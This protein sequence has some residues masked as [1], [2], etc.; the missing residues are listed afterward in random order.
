MRAVAL[1]NVEVEGLG[2]LRESLERRG[3]SV[4]E[5]P[6]YK[7]EFPEVSDFDLLIVLGG[8]MGV[9][10][11]DKFPFLKREKELIRE[12]LSQG[13]KVLG[14]CLG[15]QL[16]AEV[17]GGKVYKGEWGKE[18]G[19]KLIYPQDHLEILYG[20]EITVFHWHGDTFEIPQGCVK[21]ASSQ[22]YKN[23][24]F[25]LGNQ[26]VGLQFH[27]EVTPEDVEGWISAYR[28]ELKSKGLN[29]SEILG[30]ESLW[31]RLKIY[32]DVFT[33]YLLKL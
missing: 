18:I 5:L 24:A 2:N 1:K 15:A 14:I 11:E 12:S 22:M 20:D 25:R 32:C 26:A 9:Y 8:S 17:L 16:L 6:A 27:I 19:W 4:E 28:N 30:N 13:K 23:Q 31:K 33:E 3:V 29:E 7:G 10:E 21:M